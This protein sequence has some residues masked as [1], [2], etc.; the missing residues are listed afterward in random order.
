MVSIKTITDNQMNSYMK[1][2]EERTMKVE[3]FIFQMLSNDEKDVCPLQQR[4]GVVAIEQH[5]TITPHLQYPSGT[6]CFLT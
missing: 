6:N 1:S 5:C 3:A 4:S 2:Y